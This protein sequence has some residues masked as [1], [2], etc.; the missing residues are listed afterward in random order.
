MS[1]RSEQDTIRGNTIENQDILFV[2]YMYMWLIMSSFFLKIDPYVFVFTW[3]S[4][5]YSTKA[6]SFGL[7]IFTHIIRGNLIVYPYKLGCLLHI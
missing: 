2:F 7:L 1:E 4:T 6:E 3:L 5:P